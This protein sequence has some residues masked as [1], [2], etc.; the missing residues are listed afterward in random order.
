MATELHVR[1]QDGRVE[2]IPVPDEGLTI[3]R[4]PPPYGASYCTTNSSVSRLH[5]RLLRFG[6][7]WLL[8]DLGS[9]NGTDVNNELVEGSA[10]VRAGD[11][12]VLGGREHGLTAQLVHIAELPPARDTLAEMTTLDKELPRAS[13]LEI[14]EQT[15]F[16]DWGP[17]DRVRTSYDLVAAKYA[18]ELAGDML[19]RPL[20]RAMLQALADLVRQLGRG[21]V[22]DVGCGPGHI[23]KYATDRLGLRIAGYDISAAMIAQARRA[24]PEGE[25]HVG[26]MAEL[27]VGDGGWIG[28]I[29]MWALLHAAAEERAAIYRELARVIVP[30]GYLLNGF[31]VSGPDQPPGSTYHL[32]KWFGLKVDLPTYFVAIEDAAAE[33]DRGGFEVMAALVREPL[34][35]KELPARRCYMLGRRHA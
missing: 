30:G 17:L 23:A 6:D 18:S 32:E 7:G 4:K 34:H 11:V 12:I 27:P 8:E 16:T 24:F 28:A 1:E 25:F 29:A 26:S 20:E 31:Y 13:D 19:N 9:A 5:C 35:A 15:H 3:G 10:P 33:M 2:C 14:D 22:G 21:T